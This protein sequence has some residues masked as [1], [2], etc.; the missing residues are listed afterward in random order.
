ML[1]VF[2]IGTAGSGKSLLTAAFGE[3]LQLSKQNVSLV[4]LDPG[5]LTLPYTPNVDVRDY[6][7]IEELMQKYGLGPKRRARYGG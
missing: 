7:D 6:V 5:A 1:V 4:N 2:I 3:W